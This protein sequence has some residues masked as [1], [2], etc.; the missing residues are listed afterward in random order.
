MSPW[1][2][3]AG[4]SRPG[5]NGP[6]GIWQPLG[7][8]E[9]TFG[10][11]TPEMATRC[12]PTE[13]DDETG[14]QLKGTP[15]TSRLASSAASSPPPPTSPPS[16][17]RCSRPARPPSTR[18][19]SPSRGGMRGRAEDPDPPVG[20]LDHREHVQPCPGQGDGLEGS[21]RREARPLENAGSPPRCST[22]VRVPVGDP[23]PGGFPRRWTR[24]LSLRG[25]AARRAVA[26]SPRSGSLG[27]SAVPGHGWSRRCGAGPRG[28]AG[29]GRRVGGR[30]GRGAGAGRCR[31]A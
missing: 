30:P 17:A 7:M 29:I 28:W 3:R 31:V 22:P 11:L 1:P 26:G 24:L 4:G 20:V 15:T 19:G 9:T 10:P 13:L 14:R 12:A 2:E 5:G 16:R 27:P 8:A 21:H 18:R 6:A 23:R 25:R